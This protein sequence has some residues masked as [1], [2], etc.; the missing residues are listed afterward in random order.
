MDELQ[1]NRLHFLECLKLIG[2]VKNATPNAEALLWAE[3]GELFVSVPGVETSADATGVLPGRVRVP[4]WFVRGLAKIP[5][6]GDPLVVKVRDGKLM[7]GSV[8]APC[9]VEYESREKIELPLNATPLSILKLAYRHTPM[10]IESSG[11]AKPVADAEEWRDG[12]ITRAHNHLYELGVT[13][14]ELVELVDRKIGG[15]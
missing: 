7:I 13:R 11:L 5:P 14:E 12:Q 3:N 10:E 4:F 9:I 2:K 6:P 1:V 15:A 8:S